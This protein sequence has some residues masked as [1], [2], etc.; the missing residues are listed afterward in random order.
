M[1][2]YRPTQTTSDPLTPP[3]GGSSADRESGTMNDM[4]SDI[5]YED[6]RELAKIASENNVEIMLTVD[7][8]GVSVNIKKPRS[9]SVTT[10]T[11]AESEEE[12]DK[13]RIY[14]KIFADEEPQD[15]AEK[16]Y[17][18]CRSDELKKIIDWLIE[19]AESEEHI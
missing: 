11:T 13:I 16:I 12:K 14:S 19:Y 1:N 8:E 18:I 7:K 2:M 10:T 15:K 5:R 6:I 3:K 4:Y 9:M 17:Q